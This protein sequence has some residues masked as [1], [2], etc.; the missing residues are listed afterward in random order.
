MSCFL[1]NG[2]TS[3]P[4]VC[5]FLFLLRGVQHDK[6]PPFIIP[7]HLEQE[8]VS[9]DRCLLQMLSEINNL[10]S[11]LSAS[12]SVSSPSSQ[13]IVT[14]ESVAVFLSNGKSEWR[15]PSRQKSSFF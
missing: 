7:L 2:V 10:Q 12:L 6:S 8:E 9:T 5:V 14:A 4:L 11:I 1:R 15:S 3:A 13:D